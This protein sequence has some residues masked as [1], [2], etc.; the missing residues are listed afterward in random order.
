MKYYLG[1]QVTHGEYNRV[2]VRTNGT[3]C[4]LFSY[5]DEKKADVIIER[6][7]DY[8]D[9]DVIVDSGA[10]S[11][12]NT[13]KQV[14]RE[15]LLDCYKAIKAYR[16]DV[17]FIN[18]DV[19]PGERG[20]KPTKEQVITACREGWDNYLWFK[21]NGIQT[22]PVFHE[23]DDF[24]YLEMMKNE[25]DY[26]RI[27][28]AN[29]SSTKKRML[30]L[31]KVFANLKADYKTHGL[32][33]TSKKLMERY[34]FYSVDSVNW[35]SVVMY[36]RSSILERDYVAKMARDPDYRQ[37]ILENEIRF[38]VDQQKYIT[39]LWETRGIIWEN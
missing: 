11:L 31:D 2:M 6:L 14:D 19:I 26:I 16:N 13:G 24:K 33:A 4:V 18:L 36:G 39:T 15:D 10:Y 37:R 35:K 30:W 23:H 5:A 8:K 27:S 3:G 12:W 32:A 17:R 9:F 7:K 22:L 20:K 38:Y 1:I 29:D 34:P 21:Q 28:P 25:T